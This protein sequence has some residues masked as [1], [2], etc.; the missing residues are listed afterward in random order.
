MF[1]QPILRGWSRLILFD[2]DDFSLVT[3]WVAPQ[4]K[5][6]E[7]HRIHDRNR[8]DVWALEIV[9]GL[10]EYLR[11]HLQT[12]PLSVPIGVRWYCCAGRSNGVERVL[13]GIN[14]VLQASS[15]SKHLGNLNDGSLSFISDCFLY[16]FEA[17]AFVSDSL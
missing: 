2:N 9:S 6:Y 3:W 4:S 1:A 7:Q 8:F 15:L 14:L 16:C 12:N 13:S 5:W 17:E 11:L 10:S